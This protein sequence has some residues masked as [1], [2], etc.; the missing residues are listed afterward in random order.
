MADTDQNTTL[1]TLA[2]ALLTLSP[3]DRAKLAALLLGKQPGQAEGK[4]ATP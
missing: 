3:G 1:E 2:D 4:G